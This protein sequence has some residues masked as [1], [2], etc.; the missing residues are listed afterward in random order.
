VSADAPRPGQASARHGRASAD[1]ERATT[2]AG[3]E[4]PDV[5]VV[6]AGIIGA[7]CAYYLAR[8]GARVTVVDTGSLAAGTSSAGEGNLLVSDKPPGPEL[9]LMLRSRVLW[10][11]L[12]TDLGADAIELEAKGGLMVAAS[13]AGRQQ[14]AHLAAG[15]RAAGV[16]VTELEPAELAGYEPRLAG[17]LA[18]GAYYP[19]DAQVQ[20]VLATARLLAASGATL[21]LHTPVRGIEVDAARR[22]TGV[23]LDGRRL[24]ASAVVNATGVGA[25]AL[26]ATVGTRLPI[27][28][29]RGFILVTEPLAAPGEPPPIRRKVYAAEYVGGVSSDD[30]GLQSS[31]VVEGTRAGT[32]LIGSSRE[33]VG[34]DD[35]Y[36]LVVLRR[37]AAQAVA[38]LPFLARV[39][40]L[41][42]YRGFRPYTPDHLPVIGPDPQVAGLWHACG[43][44]GAGIGLAPVTGEIIAAQL[45]GEAPEVDCVPFSAA[46]FG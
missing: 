35:S 3:G 19:Q 43:H 37:I 15:H 9:A 22:V 32:L 44:E 2:R 42:A 45:A 16:A 28:P 40:V 4:R 36:R 29:R 38:L 23:R 6:G 27:E 17:G 30:A 5:I 46:R 7:A 31:A 8:A 13:A 11:E 1:A 26:A 14:I 18:G 39:R 34:F 20:P 10:D 41:R 25:G 24:P 21:H 12:G 33:R